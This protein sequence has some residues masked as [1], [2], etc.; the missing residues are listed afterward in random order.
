LKFP[1]SRIVKSDHT[2]TQGHMILP[3]VKLKCEMYKVKSPS[4]PIEPHFKGKERHNK[5][6]HLNVT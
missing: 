6:N 4:N 1:G 3:K 2:P 5:N